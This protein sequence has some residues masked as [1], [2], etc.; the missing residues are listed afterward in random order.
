MMNGE[1]QVGKPFTSPNCADYLRKWNRTTSNFCCTWPKKSQE[2]N[3]EPPTRFLGGRFMCENATNRPSQPNDPLFADIG[4]QGRSK[5]PLGTPGYEL[6]IGTIAEGLSCL[7]S[8]WTP[9][10]VS[11]EETIRQ[12]HTIRYSCSR[13]RPICSR[14]NF[15]SKNLHRAT[16]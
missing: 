14:A 11:N 12:R 2:T 15:Q 13:F 5:N 9:R 16:K 10:R 4:D 6:D 3:P 1:A 7:D 8:G